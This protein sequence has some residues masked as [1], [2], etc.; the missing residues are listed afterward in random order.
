MEKLDNYTSIL[1]SRI[2]LKYRKHFFYNLPEVYHICGKWKVLY[3]L[4]SVRN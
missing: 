1:A 2:N 4:E 3:V